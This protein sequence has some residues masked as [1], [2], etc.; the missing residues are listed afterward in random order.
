MLIYFRHGTAI[1]ESTRKNNNY[2]KNIYTAKASIKKTNMGQQMTGPDS[3]NGKSIWH[4]S[5]GWGSSPP[6]VETCSVKKTNIDTFTRTP[7]RVSKMNAVAR[8]QLT[9]QQTRRSEN[10]EH[11][12]APRSMNE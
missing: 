6:R 12:S 7:V 1:C 10:D 2:M 5:E 8:A 3:S 9:I 4:E 11:P